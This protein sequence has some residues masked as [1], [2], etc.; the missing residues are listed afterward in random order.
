VENKLK[1]VKL[2][3]KRIEGKSLSDSIQEFTEV[4]EQVF[5]MTFAILY[6]PNE[7]FLLQVSKDGKFQ[8][9]K[10]NISPKNVFEARIFNSKA[11]LR[12]FNDNGKGIAVTLYEQETDEE[13]GGDIC[14]IN[15]QQYLIWGKAFSANS[16]NENWTEFAEAQVGKFSVPI[17]TTSRAC[18]TAIEYLK[19]FDEQDG[20][21]AAADERLTGISEV[22]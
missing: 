12:W 8:N 22:K 7:C 18:F 9:A 13:F 6:S 10:G 5:P 3:R 14:L 19:S 4:F 17:K 15:P 21:V 1:T 16:D 11:E 20:N 2:Y